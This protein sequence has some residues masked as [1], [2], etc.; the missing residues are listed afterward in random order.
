MFIVLHYTA[1]SLVGHGKQTGRGADGT[2]PEV[3]PISRM[4]GQLI[5][6]LARTLW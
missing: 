6:F 1:Y 2:I 5:I 3:T 4:G